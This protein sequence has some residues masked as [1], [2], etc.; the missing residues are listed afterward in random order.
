[1]RIATKKL[2]DGFAFSEILIAI[3]L[4]GLISLYL[5]QLFNFSNQGTMLVYYQHIAEKLAEEPIEFLRGTGYEGIIACEQ[6][7]FPE[8]KVDIWHS[9]ADSN[10]LTADDRPDAVSLFER[11][12]SLSPTVAEDTRGYLVRVVVRPVSTS[13]SFLQKRME[14]V[15]CSAFILERP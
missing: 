2:G 4:F 13:S 15:T 8:Y 7:K 3:L 6:N 12:I 10:E 14:E 11:K 5:M 9:L 1:M